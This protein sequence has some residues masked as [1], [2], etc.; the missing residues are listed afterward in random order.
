MAFIEIPY[1]NLRLN[2]HDLFENQWLVLTCGD[3]SKN[4]FNGMTIAWGSLGTMWHRPFV[5][6]VVRPTRYTFEFMN[7]Y[8]QFTVCAFPESRKKALQ[9][10]GSRSGRDC[11]K[12]AQADLTP[13]PSVKVASPGYE[14]AELIFECK[15]IYFDDIKSEGFLDPGIEKNYPK[16]DYHG[17]YFGE[18][19]M[20]RGEKKYLS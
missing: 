11:D 3:L 8:D 12:I 6:V 13:A 2:P 1:P 17:V 16:K 9:I 20:I 10:M 18:V 19:L 7:R 4:D 15:K 14:E 5:Q